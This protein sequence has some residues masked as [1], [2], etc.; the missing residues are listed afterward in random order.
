MLL[1][2]FQYNKRFLA[3]GNRLIFISRRMAAARVGSSSVYT[4]FTGRT[5]ASIA[6]TIPSIMLIQPSFRV[7]A[8]TRVIRN[9]RTHSRI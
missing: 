2:N 5:A 9:H 7:S 4:N 3:C 8:P 6:G 1:S